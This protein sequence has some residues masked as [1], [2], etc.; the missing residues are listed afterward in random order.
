MPSHDGLT[1]VVCCDEESKVVFSCMTLACEYSMCAECIK[2]AFEDGTGEN[3]ARCP[4][5]H[6]KG[7]AVKMVAAVVG[8]VAVKAVENEL[9]SFVEFDVNTRLEIQ[10]VRSVELGALSEKARRIF[11]E[12]MEEMILKCPKCNAAFLD[13]TGCNALYCRCGCKFCAICLQDCGGDAHPHVRANHGNLFDTAKFESSKRDREKS[14]VHEWRKRIDAEPDGLKQLIK[15]HLEKA[16]ILVQE[17][18]AKVAENRTNTFLREAKKSLIFALRA[19]RLSLLRDP[20]ARIQRILDDDISPRF[21]VPDIYCLKLLKKK[22]NNVFEISLKMEDEEGKWV[23]VPIDEKE[24]TTSEGIKPCPDLLVNL[25]YALKCAVV[26][27]KGKCVLYQTRNVEFTCKGNDG[28]QPS[29]DNISVKFFRINSYGDAEKEEDNAIYGDLEIIGFN[30]N[31]RIN[32]MMAHVHST[33][34]AVL[35][36]EPIK[37]LIGAGR[38]LPLLDELKAAVPDT[39]EDLNEQQKKLAHPLYF[40][41]AVEVGGPPGTGKTKTITELTRSLLACTNYNII[42]LSERNGAIDAIAEKFASNCML[43]HADKFMGFTDFALWMNV[44][45][46]GASSVGKY[47][48]MFTLEEK[49]K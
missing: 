44:L 35:V 30:A 24:N 48:K 47:T 15:N 27:I 9:R 17:I 6:K 49:M 2:F 45:T 29:E 43:L 23:S 5:C 12:M 7:N 33:D 21:S 34:D 20:S 10:K 18:D 14:V 28:G 38:S 1:C 13:Y 40:K 25:K 42:V 46:F 41:S 8:S 3:S 4:S 16:G 36:S 22:D 39:I 32:L 26:A 31:L 37:H 19:D 11:N